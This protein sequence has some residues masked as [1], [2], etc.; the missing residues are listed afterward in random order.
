MVYYNMH[1]FTISSTGVIKVYRV[2]E[3]GE[4]GVE[5]RDA[6][7]GVDWMEIDKMYEKEQNAD[8]TRYRNIGRGYF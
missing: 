8:W 6:I 3:R 5:L 4:Y 7:V 1:V 2:D